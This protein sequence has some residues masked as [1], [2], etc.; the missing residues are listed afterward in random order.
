MPYYKARKWSEG[1]RRELPGRFCFMA[2]STG[3]LN[4][5]WPKRQREKT[6]RRPKAE[7]QNAVR[8]FRPHPLYGEQ[9]SS[10]VCVKRCDIWKIAVK[11][12]TG[13]FMQCSR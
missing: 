6:S 3:C 11:G 8:H 12:F 1:L 13:I 10:A 5:V 7:Q 2:F 4:G 9:L